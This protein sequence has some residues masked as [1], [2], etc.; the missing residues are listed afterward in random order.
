M[1]LAADSPHWASESELGELG[2]GSVRSYERAVTNGGLPPIQSMEYREV[3]QEVE[4]RVPGGL[5]GITKH[6]SDVTRFSKALNRKFRL[7]T[8]S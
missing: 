4:K 8:T 5:L 2:V 7:P 1:I 6:Y 3:L